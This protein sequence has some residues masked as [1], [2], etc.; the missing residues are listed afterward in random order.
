VGGLLL[1]GIA[2]SRFSQIRMTWANCTIESFPFQGSAKSLLHGHSALRR[3]GRA[4]RPLSPNSPPRTQPGLLSWGLPMQ[5]LAQLLHVPPTGS[6][7][8][9]L[10]SQEAHQIGNWN[11]VRPRV[12]TKPGGQTRAIAEPGR[13]NQGQS[14][15]GGDVTRGGWVCQAEL[16]AP[17]GS[18]GAGRDRPAPKP[19]GHAITGSARGRFAPPPDG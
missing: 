3:D 17:W 7:T 9:P 18:A 12:G 15:V 1:V 11:W 14:D 5:V 4:G 19:S 2:E 8:L 16:R 10:R 13:K 6:M